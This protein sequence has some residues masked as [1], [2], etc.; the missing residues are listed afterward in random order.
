[1][2]FFIY[3]RLQIIQMRRILLGCVAALSW[4]LLLAQ[5]EPRI[6]IHQEE[7]EYY[8]TLG[9][10][11]DKQFDALNGTV[12][13]PV[14]TSDKA[15]CTLEKIVFGYHP[16]WMGTAYRNYRW[17]LLSD[18]CYFAYEVNP[19]TGAAINTH[20]WATTDVVDTALALGKKVHLCATLFSSHATFF[21]NASAKQTLITNLINAI[22]S[23]G[24]HG[25][26]I[27]FEGVPSTESAN[28][29][30]FLQDLCTQVHA[31][32][33]NFKVSIAGPSVNWSSTYDIAALNGYLD[34]FVI[35]G[36]D[37]YY[38]GSTTAGP[39]SGLY[40]RLCN[41][42]DNLSRSITYYLSA[43]AS[44]NKI[45][46]ALP[47]YGREW[48]TTSS[49]LGAT[50]VAG[51]SN[52][53]TYK[54]VHDSDSGWYDNPYARWEPK[55]LTPYFVFN[56]GS[57]WRQCFIDDEKSLEYR[58]DMVYLRNIAGIGIWALGYDDGYSALWNLIEDKLTT[59]RTVACSDT[60]YD[61]GGPGCNHF[62]NENFTWTLS[63]DGATS[64]S[65]TFTGFDLE[66]GYDS[67]WIYNGPSVASPLLGRYS[68]TAGP[69]TV[70]ATGGDMTLK[71]HSDNAT[72]H[73]GF[74]AIWNCSVDMVAP[75]TSITADSWETHNFTANFTDSDNVGT[76]DLLYQVLDY[77]GTE[78]RANGAY[79]FFNDNFTTAIHPEWTVNTGTW[80]I[81]SGRVNQTNEASTNSNLSALVDQHQGNTY[82]Y[83]W[84]MNIGGSLTNRRAGMHFFCDSVKGVNRGNSYFVYFR[85]DENKVQLYKCIDD[86]YSL[87]T[88]DVY[89][90]DSMTWYDCKIL[91]NTVTGNMK[92]FLNNVQVSEWTD[93]A[94]LDSGNS[95]S[96][97]TASS[98]TLYDDVK[99]YRS[100]NSTANITIGTGKEVRYQNANP[101][102]PAC[103]IKSIIT[104]VSGLWSSAASR[105]VNIDW[106]APDTS[107]W[108]Y[109][110]LAFD[111]DTSSNNSQASAN[112]D[113]ATDPHSGIQTYLFAVGYAP[114]DSSV[115]DWT[116]VGN[117]L[118]TGASG[119]SL[120]MDTMVYVSLKAVN[121]AG[122]ISPVSHSDGFYLTLLTGMIDNAAISEV[123]V[124]PNPFKEAVNVSFNLPV[125]S[126]IT[127]I[128]EGAKGEILS[129]ES[130]SYTAGIHVVPVKIPANFAAQHCFLKIMVD[131]KEIREFQLIHVNN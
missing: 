41:T 90:I 21:A 51:T 30:A 64:L 57:K 4:S 18:L 125:E 111:I 93:P 129:R 104:D 96:L 108:I 89:A 28:L 131:Q 103:R 14:I 1:M 73:A 61:L 11:T 50:T 16:Y 67:L 45:I 85:S 113:A 106:S 20:S 79:G 59:C 92:A 72:T 76:D 69:G 54:Y 58:Y 56:D 23:R 101:A 8:N 71:F 83:H 27:D 115:I 10:T 49:S 127:I 24:A 81:N 119:L 42:S 74:Q 112:W 88:N 3:L 117:V 110:G 121:G 46:L 47:Y 78:W 22:Q 68:G 29:T 98:N 17:D 63:P 130:G 34:Y 124:F 100:R 25:I 12:K 123:K 9:Y 48:Q 94:P 33:A 77:N 13:M 105:D 40:S 118:S 122:L 5:E 43:G 6:S 32:N 84:Q 99:V 75:L 82:L 36:Y 120:L 128:L 2:I 15:G 31:A 95:I 102:T 91:F 114:G 38:G 55:S 107:A 53:R 66:S 44:N 26:N 87:Q 37:Y 86:V 109:D 60:L 52:S 97:R 70:T 116:D 80:V 39:V 62:D 126:D 7:Q 19:A 65:M 35:M